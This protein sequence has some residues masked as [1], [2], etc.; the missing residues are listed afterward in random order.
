MHLSVRVLD[1]FRSNVKG[2]K[3]YD[4][5]RML[6]KLPFELRSKITN[7][8]YL[9]TIKARPSLAASKGSTS[10]GMRAKPAQLLLAL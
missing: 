5:S 3:P 7:Y 2:V 6:E 1:F 8:L 4:R 9:P 10:R